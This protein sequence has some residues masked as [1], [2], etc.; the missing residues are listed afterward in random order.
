MS[1]YRRMRS[2][3]C[4]RSR[5]PVAAKFIESGALLGPAQH[6]VPKGRAFEVER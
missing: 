1:T 3:E 6:P 4:L 5:P 2:S